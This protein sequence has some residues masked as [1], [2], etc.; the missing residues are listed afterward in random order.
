M[1]N[2]GTRRQFLRWSIAAGSTAVLANLVEQRGASAAQTSTAKLHDALTLAVTFAGTW[3]LDPL[4]GPNNNGIYLRFMFDPL[5]GVDY[6][7]ENLSKETGVAQNWSVSSD[8]LTYTF[9]LRPGIKFHDGSE[10]TAEDVQFSLQ[11][12]G[13]AHDL[14]TLGKSTFANIASIN[15][16]DAH[17]LQVQLK[18][19]MPMLLYRLSPL[20]DTSG[21][22]VPKAYYDRV[23][24]A[25]F[26]KQPMGSGPYKLVSYETDSFLKFEQAFSEHWA[27]GTPRFKQVELRQVPNENSRVAMLRSGA[28]DFIDVGVEH[29]RQLPSPDFRIFRSELPDSMV[30]LFNLNAKDRNAPTRD[31]RVRQALAYAIDKGQLSKAF[32]FGEAPVSGNAFGGQIGGAPIAPVPYAPEKARQLLAAAGYSPGGKVLKLEIQ[33]QVRSAVPQMRQLAQAIQADWKAV[34]VDS[35][36][37]HGDY[38]TW[39]A[40]AVARSLPGNEVE[41]LDYGGRVDNSGIA[42]FFYGCNGLLSTVCDPELDKLNAAWNSAAS[43]QDYEELGRKDEKYI[44]EHQYSI[45]LLNVPMVFAGNSQ[46]APSYSPGKIAVVFNERGLVWNHS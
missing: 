16:L 38:G 43:L 27:I 33:A 44:T 32:F 28:A 36:I 35:T 3:A 4:K 37:V 20:L 24:D 18:D 40:K 13:D 5:V 25:G 10:L 22:I 29:A 14:T 45:P 30:V 23:G 19:R 17:R 46:I 31:I 6:R 12:L 41:I 11:R 8:G 9:D 26:S 34:G 39:R 15:I 7:G 2:R 21:L 42:I 1:D